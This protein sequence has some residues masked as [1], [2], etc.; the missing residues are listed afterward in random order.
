MVFQYSA[1]NLLAS[2]F[3]RSQSIFSRGPAIK[4]SRLYAPPNVT[5]R[6]P[7]SLAHGESAINDNRLSGDVTAGVTRQEQERANEFFRIA[8]AAERRH[9]APALA[10][11][12][13]QERGG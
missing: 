8:P 13:G 1:V 12:F 9:L 3:Q 5:L 7:D 6:M 10:L 11:F 2:E 4:L